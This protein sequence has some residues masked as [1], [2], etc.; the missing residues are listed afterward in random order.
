MSIL[1]AIS[2]SSAP[3]GIRLVVYG[4]EKVGK[5]TLACDAPCALL[6]PLEVGFAGVKVNKVPMLSSFYHVMQL[7][8]EITASLEQGTF[9]YKTL[10][11]DS[12]TA[13][14]RMIHQSV[15]ESDPGFVAGNKKIVTM[16][17]ALGGFGKAYTY[18][19]ELFNNFLTKCD[20]LAVRF[21][22][23]IVL[24]CHRFVAKV[25]DPTAGEY[26][27][28]DILLHSP[29]NQKNYG[30][31]E[32]ITQWAD[33]I[34]FLHE[35]IFVTEGKTMS[36]G[37]SANQGRV[38]EITRSPSFV[39]GNRFNMETAIPLP[40]EGGWNH[41]ANSVYTSSGIDIYKRPEQEAMLG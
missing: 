18:S 2:H 15:L 12:A 13:L 32:I 17:S 28:F 19:N 6:I 29:K 21:G 3:T 7:L 31:R 5:T 20:D 35:P 23:N 22:I 1:G 41:I 38:L 8:D 39:A 33:I 37:I 24:T 27:C 9:K 40:R 14:E 36:K 25:L 34:G 10:V 11:F 30:K 16:E 4:A 26:D